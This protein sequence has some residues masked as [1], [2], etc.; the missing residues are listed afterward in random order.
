MLKLTTRK[1]KEKLNS[2]FVIFSFKYCCCFCWAWLSLYL[3]LHVLVTGL[4]GQSAREFLSDLPC[5]IRSLRC[6]FST[7]HAYSLVSLTSYN[8][9][10]RTTRFCLVKIVG[11]GRLL[12]RSLSHFGLLTVDCF[13]SGR[14]WKIWEFLFAIFRLSGKS[15][16]LV[17]ACWENALYCS[18]K[19]FSGTH[20]GWWM[21][22][23]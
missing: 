9:S 19:K 3:K 23:I 13:L 7:F 10:F 18:S 17:W 21:C 12:F 11:D 4:Y 5:R 2:W 15:K 22:Q 14:F 1:W 8:C 16:L 6:V 20:L